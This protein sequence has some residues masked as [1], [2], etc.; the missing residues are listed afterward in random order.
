VR[1][2]VEMRGERVHLEMTDAF[3]RLGQRDVD[4]VATA[5]VIVE[6]WTRQEIDAGTMPPEPAVRAP[7]RFDFGASALSALGTNG[8]TWVGGALSA[9]TRLGPLCAG[10]LVRGETDTRA[11]GDSSTVAQD[12]YAVSAFATV[13]LPWRAGPFVVEPGIGVGY[14]W[15]HVVTHHHDAMNNLLDVPTSDHQL[16]TGA[17]V[18]LHYPFGSHVAA[19]GDLWGDVCIAR[20]N[21]QFGPTAS[22]RAALGIWIEVP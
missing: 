10:A 1:V 6:S 20:S 19:F 3:D 5:A 12:S 17:H 16:Q 13:D 21:S 9:C 22:V 2:Q 11:T 7:R 18:A 14:G 4:D 15:L 8:T